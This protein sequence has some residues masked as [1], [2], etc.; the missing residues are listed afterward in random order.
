[1]FIDPLHEYWVQVFPDTGL[2]LIDGKAEV[3]DGESRSFG[4]SSPAALKKA[5]KSSNNWTSMKSQ[6]FGCWSEQ[7]LQQWPR[8]L[9][10]CSPRL[11]QKCSWSWHRWTLLKHPKLML[12]HYI[13][14]NYPDIAQWMSQTEF[15]IRLDGLRLQH[16]PSGHLQTSRLILGRTGK[17]V[18]TLMPSTRVGNGSSVPSSTVAPALLLLSALGEIWAL[19]F[20]RTRVRSLFT[21]VTNS[22]TNSLTPV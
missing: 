8:L 13:S 19:C 15:L 20:Y 9:Q 17:W 6:G 22:L 7:S 2:A 1:M 21:L 16:Q 5:D 12:C 10:K 18:S 14:Q 11:L 4:C 3:R